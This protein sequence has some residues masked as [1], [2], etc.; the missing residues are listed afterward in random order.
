MHKFRIIK[1]ACILGYSFL[2]QEMGNTFLGF[3]C[4]LSGNYIC[5]ALSGVSRV[6]QVGQVPLAPLEGGATER[7]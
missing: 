6:W 3:S 2:V 1:A 5:E 4:R 7:S